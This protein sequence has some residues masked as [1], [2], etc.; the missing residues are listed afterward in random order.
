MRGHEKLVAMRHAGYVPDSVWIDTDAERALP[1]PG[2][3]HAID[4]RK[5][6]LQTEPGE[7][8]WRID[9]RCAVGLIC[10]VDG[11]RA[12]EV[13]AMRDACI[14]AGAKRV[15]ATV[16]RRLGAGEFITFE[17][18][19]MTD[20]DGVHDWTQPTFDEVANG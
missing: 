17:L 15:I 10:Y 7:K 4:N 11:S 2:D 18:I 12:L 19:E 5:A 16:M 20:T 9:L 14:A 13:R 6:H 1:M 8:A 3:W